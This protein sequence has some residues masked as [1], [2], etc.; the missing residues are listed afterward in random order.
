MISGFKFFKKDWVP[1]KVFIC[2][3]QNE[4]VTECKFLN[5]DQRDFFTAGFNYASGNTLFA[6]VG[7][8]IIPGLDF[9]WETLDYDLQVCFRWG[10]NTFYVHSDKK[11]VIE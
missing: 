8:V 2:N 11:M 10:M 6:E 3:K 1:Y 9:E 4:V 7:C 5:P